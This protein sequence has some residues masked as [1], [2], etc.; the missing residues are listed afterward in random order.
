MDGAGLSRA[1]ARPV[2]RSIPAQPRLENWLA[3]KRQRRLHMSRS[4]YA[5]RVSAAPKNSPGV[6]ARHAPRVLESLNSEGETRQWRLE[7]S[8]ARLRVAVETRSSKA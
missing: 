2:M 4:L 1:P 7:H 6:I 5:S 8:C 3:A